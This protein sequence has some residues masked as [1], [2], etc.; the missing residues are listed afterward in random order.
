MTTEARV[1]SDDVSVPEPN[2]QNHRIRNKTCFGSVAEE[3]ASVLGPPKE[4]FKELESRI[5]E[6]A[7]E[8]SICSVLTYYELVW[9]I[10]GKEG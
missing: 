3:P 8:L 9:K 7:S 5:E 10:S 2:G 1:K 6:P 4:L